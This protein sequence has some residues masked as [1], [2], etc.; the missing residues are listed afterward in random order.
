MREYSIVPEQAKT[1]YPKTVAV[2]EGIRKS[3]KEFDTFINK[4]QQMTYNYI[5]ALES[6]RIK[7]HLLRNG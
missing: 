1:E 7:R 6:K 3:N 2:L 5:Q 4:V